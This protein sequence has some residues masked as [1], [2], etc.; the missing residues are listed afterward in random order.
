[1]K[2]AWLLLLVAAHACANTVINKYGQKYDMDWASLD[3]RPT[4]QWF[5]D[6]K[7]GIFIHWGVYSVPAWA[8]V[9][10]YAEWYEHDLIKNP[11]SETARF[12]NQT[13]G[14]HFK[15]ADFAHMF[16]AELFDADQWADLFKRSGAKYVVPTSK[17]HEGFT[18]WP[19]PESWNWNSVD[20]GPHRDLIGELTTAL[21]KKDIHAGIYYSL[22]EWFHP[23]YLRNQ[24][25]Y[26]DEIMLPQLYDVVKRYEPDLM[27]ADGYENLDSHQW[28][29]I[30]F[31]TWLYN[32]SPVADRVVVNDRWG[33]DTNT[34]HGGFYTPEYSAEVFLDKKWEECSGIDVHS[35][36]YNRNTPADKYS[37][38]ED[39]ILLLVRTVS[40]GGN[41]LLDI[42]PDADGSI[43]TIMQERLLQIG[44]WLGVNGE[45]I[46]DTVLWH[47]Q[48]EGEID[49]TTLRYTAN[50]D[51]TTVYAISTEWP[52]E[53]YID[54]PTPKPTPGQT[55][56]TLLGYDGGPLVYE[57][58]GEKG[59]R[60]V[61]PKLPYKKL[62]CEHA[63]AFK[64]T[65]VA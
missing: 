53:L 42:G 19:S 56:I 49:A 36:G 4:P 12:H 2:A 21:K 18:L 51:G 47:T 16:K 23:I 39:L 46:Y 11:G 10:V 13:Y 50:K 55:V 29:T 57:P 8:P 62:P 35:F 45:A 24:S 52:S 34:R 15:Y 41:L 26:I 64:L 20:V 17:H 25:Q 14:E 7:F 44:E 1:M 54:I 5:Q 30:E 43:P 37:T 32:D 28:R 40:N 3:K 31:I 6:A 61:L 63:W 22:Y 33:T 9:G 27:W 60:V 38:A 65:N 59:V 48:Q 58:L